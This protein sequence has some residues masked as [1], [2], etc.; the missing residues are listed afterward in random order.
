MNYHVNPA[1][2]SLAHSKERMLEFERA[3]AAMGR[4]QGLAIEM[5]EVTRAG[6]GPLPVPGDPRSRG[7]AS[8]TRT[9]G[10]IDPA[11][12]TQALAKGARAHGCA[13]DPARFS[14]GDR[15]LPATADES[16]IV[17][18]DKGDIRR[19]LG[20]QR[21]RLLRPARRRVVQALRRADRPDGGDEPPVSPHR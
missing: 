17:H 14:P 2:V 9:D 7:R 19:R 1:P 13:E 5:L 15:R 20:G 3:R 16:W 8:T 12:L 10:D 4:Y 18:T 11:Q 6:Q 21:R